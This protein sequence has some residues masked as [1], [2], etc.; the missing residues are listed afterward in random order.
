M[1]PYCVTRGGGGGGVGR[2]GVLPDNGSA[3]EEHFTV[4][5]DMEQIGDQGREK[6]PQPSTNGCQ[7]VL[8]VMPIGINWYQISRYQ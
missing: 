5:R 7:L 6:G 8:D 3:T 2:K 1:S 4:V